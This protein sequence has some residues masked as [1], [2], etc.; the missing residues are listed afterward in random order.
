M[1]LP[2]TLTK[3][4]DVQ[5]P[6]PEGLAAVPLLACPFC[7]GRASGT[8]TIKYAK[9]HEAWWKD[10]TRI[11]EAHFCNCM[12]C[13]VTNKGLLGHQTP[14]L[15]VEHWNTRSQANVKDQAHKAVDLHPPCSAIVSMVVELR[16]D[17]G[18]MHGSD[19]ESKRW[20]QELLLNK[21]LALFSE[22]MGDFIGEVK[23]IKVN[24][25]DHLPKCIICGDEEPC[26]H[27]FSEPNATL[28]HEEGGKEQ[29]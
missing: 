3:P 13:G 16:Y 27:D 7:G 12:R 14:A 24:H 1:S 19:A 20:F 6:S 8:G 29:Q 18:D 23:V 22:E 25:S 21:P 9:T 26:S 10:G 28:S 17:A 11:T 2:D 15:A 4:D 5:Q